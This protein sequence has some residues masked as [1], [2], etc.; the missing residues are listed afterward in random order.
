MRAPGFCKLRR[1]DN[2][3]RVRQGFDRVESRFRFI[4]GMLQKRLWRLPEG[5]NGRFLQHN[6]RDSRP[7]NKTLAVNRRR[8]QVRAIRALVRPEGRIAGFAVRR[9]GG[10]SH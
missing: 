2:R 6:I 10:M 8:G 1:R 4:R 7:G 5:R 3:L 9:R